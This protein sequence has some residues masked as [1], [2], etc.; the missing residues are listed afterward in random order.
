MDALVEKISNATG[1]NYTFIAQ[2]NGRE[3]FKE[4]VNQNQLYKNRNNGT[5][6]F[7]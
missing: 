2:L 6:A 4:T 1:G 3:I 5:S 7:A